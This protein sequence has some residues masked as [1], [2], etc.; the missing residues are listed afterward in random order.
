MYRGR[1][2]GVRVRGRARGVCTVVGRVACV[3][4]A[5]GKSIHNDP[6]KDVC[7][8]IERHFQTHI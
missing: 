3:A 4:C 7:I 2:R 1:E 8:I 6:L 5:V